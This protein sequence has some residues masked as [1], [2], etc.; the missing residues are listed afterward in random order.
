MIVKIY[1]TEFESYFY[2][3]ELEEY[4]EYAITSNNKYKNE[5]IDGIYYDPDKKINDK[6]I[7][8]EQCII[9]YENGVIYISPGENSEF[10][11]Y[12]QLDVKKWSDIKDHNLLVGSH[13]YFDFSSDYKELYYHEKN[14]KGKLL[15]DLDSKENLL[16]G[17]EG[18]KEELKTEKE[19]GKQYTIPE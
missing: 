18:H 15:C 4:K 12:E 10:K 9:S 8:Q 13:F 5:F 7:G 2:D 16:I 11:I 17:R 1:N 19:A 3:H 6:T 14:N